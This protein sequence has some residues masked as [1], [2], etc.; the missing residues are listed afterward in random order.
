MHP[1]TVS[2]RLFA[3]FLALAC[4][5][6]GAVGP[7]RAGTVKYPAETPILTVDIPDGWK[8]AIIKGDL[9]VSTADRNVFF[10]L[11]KDS[12]AITAE[13]TVSGRKFAEGAGLTDIVDTPSDD[14]EA[15]G[16][17][18]KSAYVTGKRQGAEWVAVVGVLT[19]PDGTK[20]AMFILADTGSIAAHNQELSAI[21]E[22]I[23]AAK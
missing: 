23:K 5:A 13:P 3:S 18:K 8:S 7:L 10:S 11:S 22:S 4:V 9:V 15:N 21:N 17:K 20:C 16:V 1:R 6:L 14:E 2:R 12:P 19:L